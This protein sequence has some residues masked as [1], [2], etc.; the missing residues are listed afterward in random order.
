MS[1]TCFLPLFPSLPRRP[2][3]ST[4]PCSR[5]A[6]GRAL[7]LCRASPSGI[8]GRCTL[9]SHPSPSSVGCFPCPC[10]AHLLAP[11][12]PFVQRPR[13]CR[14]HCLH[15]MSP[16]GITV[17]RA[18]KNHGQNPLAQPYVSK[19]L[20]PLQ[21]LHRT[22]AAAL[23]SC[24]LCAVLFTAAPCAK[25]LSTAFLHPWSCMLI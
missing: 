23:V 4:A 18:D 17:P 6:T 15:W 20:H 25:P 8:Q 2:H 7:L 24:W 13:I 14:Y 5:I 1:V 9:T 10:C 19:A 22:S 11:A 21:P 12:R 16:H 3:A